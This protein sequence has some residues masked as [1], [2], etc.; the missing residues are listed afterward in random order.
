MSDEK[1]DVTRDWD[2]GAAEAA[3]DPRDVY[4][5]MST[6]CPVASDGSGTWTLFRHADVVQAACEPALFSSTVS[7]HLNVPNGMDGEEHARF[8]AVIDRYFGEE[9]ISRLEPRFRAIARELVGS[10][11]RGVT[12]DAVR[13]LDE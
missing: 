5:E 12:I 1:S 10:L 13:H 4:D 8:R 9:R 7:R 11:P 3:T 2:P 6:R